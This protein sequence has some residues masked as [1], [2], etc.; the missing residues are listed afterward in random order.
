M[1]VKNLRL[2]YLY[3]TLKLN[4]NFFFELLSYIM[5]VMV[6]MGGLEPPTS[7]L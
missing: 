1:R 5:E 6:A 2:I 3:E 4:S 7:A